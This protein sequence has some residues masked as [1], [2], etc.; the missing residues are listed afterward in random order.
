MTIGSGTPSTGQGRT[1][2]SPA[3][4]LNSTVLVGGKLGG[5]KTNSK[6]ISS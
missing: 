4:T 2:S 1:A 5:S 6:K 3:L